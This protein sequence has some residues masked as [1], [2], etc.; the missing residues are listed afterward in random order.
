MPEHVHCT[1]CVRAVLEAVSDGDTGSS[2]PDRDAQRLGR[3]RPP[4][5]P[6]RFAYP[7]AKLTGMNTIGSKSVLT[8]LSQPRAVRQ[9]HRGD[10]GHSP[11]VRG[12]GDTNPR[13]T[14]PRR[15]SHVAFWSRCS[16]RHDTL[17][18]KTQRVR[19]SFWYVSSGPQSCRV[20]SSTSLNPCSSYN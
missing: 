4:Q 13:R 5:L 6:P 10:A 15:S 2:V 11:Q 1:R 14:P 3:H 16:N 20:T 9:T 18:L 19:S 12:H 17:R 8:V 7:A